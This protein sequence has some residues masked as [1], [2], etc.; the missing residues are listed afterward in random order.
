MLIQAGQSKFFATSI[1]KFSSIEVDFN[2]ISGS[3]EF[4]V[5]SVIFD[6][7]KNA[8]IRTRRDQ[9]QLVK[10]RMIQLLNE[11]LELDLS[12]EREDEINSALNGGFQDLLSVINEWPTS[13]NPALIESKVEPVSALLTLEEGKVTVNLEESL[14][15][16]KMVLVRVLYTASTD[17]EIELVSGNTYQELSIVT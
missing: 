14:P 5:L 3:G 12:A 10:E 11:E 9:P 7:T 13:T 1:G 6:D 16:N 4:E 17:S 2:Q 8:S 15:S